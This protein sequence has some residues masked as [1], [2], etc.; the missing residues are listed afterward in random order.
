MEDGDK[1]MFTD[2]GTFNEENERY[3]FVVEII[4]N[5]EAV[6]KKKFTLNKGNYEA[7]K[8]LYGENSDAWV[9]KVM[10]VAKTRV[11]NPQTGL[12]VD[13][14][15]LVAPVVTADEATVAAAGV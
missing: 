10:Q 5:G 2:V 9:G 8:A 15:E 6:E 13:S 4:K 11:R 1:I 12:K 14:I 3:V 7:T